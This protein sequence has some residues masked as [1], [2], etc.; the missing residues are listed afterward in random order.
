MQIKP[1]ENKAGIQGGHNALTLLLMAAILYPLSTH[2]KVGIGISNAGHKRPLL[3][4]V[5]L[6]PSKT[7]ALIRLVYHVMVEYVGEPLKRFAGSCTSMPILRTLPPMIGII[8]GGYSL[9]T[10]YHHAR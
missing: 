6:Y 1:K 8:S 3:S 10:G 5:F 2:L 7:R 4:V 9:F